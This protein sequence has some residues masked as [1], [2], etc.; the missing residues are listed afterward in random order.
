[1]KINSLQLNAFRGATKPLK[2]EFDPAKNITMIFGENGNGK[3][4]IAD[5]IVCLCTENHGSL[6]DKS[7]IDK[8]FYTS[9]NNK[10]EDVSIALNA[11]SKVFTAKMSRTGVF[12]KT[13]DSGHPMV[14]HLRRSQIT[15]LIEEQPAKRYEKL[16][17]YIDV[18]NVAKA[19]DTLRKAKKDADDELRVTIATL[20]N[21]TGTL[22]NTWKAEGSPAKSWEQWA[23]IESAKDITAEMMRHK[24][25][26]EVQMGWNSA[27]ELRTKLADDNQGYLDAEKARIQAEQKLREAQEKDQNANADLLILLQ[28]A[29]NYI[30]RK[31]AIANC[32]VC[33]NGMEKE[34]V[35][36]SLAE[37]IDSMEVIKN[38]SEEVRKTRQVTAGKKQ[39]WESAR[40]SLYQKVVAVE[41]AIEAIKEAPYA[42][43]ADKLAFLKTELTE[44][45]KITAFLT[46]YDEINTIIE[47][48]KQIVEKIKTAI[49]QNNLIKGQYQAIKESKGK[50][51]KIDKLCDAMRS[52]L[53]I[54]EKARKDFVQDELTAISSEV[55]RLYQKIHPKEALGGISLTLKKS[56]KNSLELNADFYTKKGVTPQSVYSESHLDTLG[57]CV[58]IALAK[59]YG[60][61]NSILIL[62]DVVMSVDENHLDR[63]IELLHDDCGEF[64]HILITTHYRPWRDRYR[65]N[66]AP[67]SKVHFV[68]L[69][70][71][72]LEGGIRIQNGK[73]A[74]DEL[75]EALVNLQY[76]DRQKITSSAGVI[77]ENAL[78]FLSLLY[79][80]K[81]QRK[82]KNDYQLRELLDSISKK[83]MSSLKV[84]HFGKDASTGKYLE[85][86]V[87]KEIDLKEIFEKIKELAVV[88]NWVG[89]HYNYDG[90][91]V[92]DKDVETFGQITLELAELLTCPDSGQFPDR[93][94]SGSYWETKAG[95]IRLHPL[96][97]PK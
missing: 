11:D 38:L 77:L 34:A 53:E 82:P 21:A 67:G 93:D 60:A 27:R 10:P 58:F 66:R 56:A 6:D 85:T 81:L 32:P 31:D 23:K 48:Q 61:Q 22:E 51:E 91:L 63:F 5:S 96:R 47:E 95:S 44:D 43:L 13:P 78:D 50:S 90:S 87:T 97:E 19:E 20:M 42:G 68:E 76:L 8:A 36:K 89:A 62:D 73:V 55:D 24:L 2:L 70:T 26:Q 64:A 1:M 14:R 29:K 46:G 83:L 25:L 86:S 80:C 84:Q 7:S 16:Q 59:R 94:R 79:G 4:T 54:V 15:Q 28:N 45:E 18:N 75:R 12:T 92:S 37:K 35:V 88:R 41:Q 9:L 33:D 30:S 49:D 71:W 3:S 74:C 57:I 17:S 69:R 65:Y 39:V 72:S 52:T 40:S